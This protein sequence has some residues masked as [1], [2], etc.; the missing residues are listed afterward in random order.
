MAPDFYGNRVTLPGHSLQRGWEAV[1]GEMMQDT[2]PLA[3][4]SSLM[5]SCLP[6]PGHLS[7]GALDA[8]AEP[9]NLL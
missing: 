1:Y 7:A 2:V 3:F 9:G 6:A 5:S 8:T 4:P